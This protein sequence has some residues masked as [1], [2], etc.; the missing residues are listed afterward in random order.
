MTEIT[1]KKHTDRKSEVI[2]K[3]NGQTVSLGFITFFRT[4]TPGETDDIIPS[5]WKPAGNLVNLCRFETVD[6]DEAKR[7]VED[8]VKKLA[9]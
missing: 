5:A 8:E 9:A 6:L 7:I 2:V 3:H 4:P 1:F